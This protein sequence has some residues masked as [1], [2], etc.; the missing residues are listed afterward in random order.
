MSRSHLLLHWMLEKEA[1][2]HDDWKQEEE[3]AFGTS[4]TRRLREDEK[5]ETANCISSSGGRCGWR[6]RDG[7]RE[8]QRNPGH[9]DFLIVLSAPQ[10]SCC[11]VSSSSFS[12][13]QQTHTQD[14]VTCSP[15]DETKQHQ[16]PMRRKER[17]RRDKRAPDVHPETEKRPASFFPSER[18]PEFWPRVSHPILSLTF[19]LSLSLT[20]L[21]DFTMICLS[22]SR[23]LK[24]SNG[25]QRT[26]HHYC[27][28][29]PSDSSRADVEF[30]MTAGC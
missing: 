18:L 29:S 17:E 10:F 14:N 8:Q 24:E 11:F 9:R 21:A 19:I 25:T 27:T 3:K 16:E 1:H 12:H 7:N 26:H 15:C 30:A 5:K 13:T 23:D 28:K 6:G 2:P 4:R 20:H 22:F